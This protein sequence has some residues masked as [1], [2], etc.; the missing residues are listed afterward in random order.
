M[1]VGREDEKNKLKTSVSKVKRNNKSPSGYYLGVRKKERNEERRGGKSVTHI[2]T[3]IYLHASSSSSS[4]QLIETCK[5][6]FGPIDARA[7]VCVCIVNEI[8]R[9]RVVAILP[10][11]PRSSDR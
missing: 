4:K 2:P 1:A 8:N 3:S 10:A 7:C 6:K 9:N 5:V 11:V